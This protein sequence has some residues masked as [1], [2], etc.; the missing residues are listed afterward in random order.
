VNKDA[1]WLRPADAAFHVITL[2]DGGEGKSVTV[3]G[4]TRRL[5]AVNEPDIGEAVV[6]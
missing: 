5:Y 3:T 1:R 4:I 2:L 6:Q